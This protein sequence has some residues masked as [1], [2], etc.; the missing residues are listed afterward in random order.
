MDIE[1]EDEIEY[2]YTYILII[3]EERGGINIG[4]NVYEGNEEDTGR[5]DD[6]GS[7]VELEQASE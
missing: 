7:E 6:I 1:Q 4:D 3:N 5:N 2:E